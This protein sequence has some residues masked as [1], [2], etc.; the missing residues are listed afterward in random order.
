[1]SK[2]IVAVA[3]VVAG[4]LAIVVAYGLLGRGI[5]LERGAQAALLD[6]IEIVET[7]AA[8]QAEDTGALAARQTDLVTAQAELATVEA[9][10]VS[11]RLA[12]P[13][14]LD[15]TEVLAH[16]V[17]TAAIHDVTLRQIQ[18]HTLAPDRDAQ[19][20]PIWHD[21]ATPN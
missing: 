21:L 13:S 2:R 15:S 16:V 1:M 4:V 18:A 5:L 17:S 19:S 3:A 20:R 6:Q 12:F 14:E 8:N 11:A 10:L 7:A 9:E